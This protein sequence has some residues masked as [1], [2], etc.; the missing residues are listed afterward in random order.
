MEKEVQA[1]RGEGERGRREEEEE[2]GRGKG[3]ERDG[4]AKAQGR[5][6]EAAVRVG[7]GEG[8]RRV[9]YVRGASQH[10]PRVHCNV[11][12]TSRGGEHKQEENL[13]LAL[14]AE[15]PVSSQAPTR[16]HW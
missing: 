16:A 15:A 12:L 1:R 3:K 5:E 9:G 13:C 6:G 14:F 2:T 4:G 10:L 8:T 7:V 11:S